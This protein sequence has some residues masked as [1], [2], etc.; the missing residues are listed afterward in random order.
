MKEIDKHQLK[1]YTMGHGEKSF[2]RV[3]CT[4]GWIG[5][6]RYASADAQASWLE[7]D[8]SAHMLE[9]QQYQEYLEQGDPMFPDG[10][11]YNQWSRHKQSVMKQ[12]DR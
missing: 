1:S 10:L 12:L 6:A 5:E 7:Y 9:V 2:T 11:T 3:M 4:C 8:R